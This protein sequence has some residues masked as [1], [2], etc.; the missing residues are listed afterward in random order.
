[1]DYVFKLPRDPADGRFAVLPIVD[2]VIIAPGPGNDEQPC[3]GTFNWG[4]NGNVY[5]RWAALDL[6][7]ICVEG[8][9][10][11]WPRFETQ[12]C[13]WQ[14]SPG[15]LPFGAWAVSEQESL[16]NGVIPIEVANGGFRLKAGTHH[17]ELGDPAG[18]TCS[19]RCAIDLTIAW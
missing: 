8:K 15:F 3:A 14:C 6:G 5:D 1:M 17:F 13:G 2:N 9:W 12:A 18:G 16:A 7:I 11:V 10:C 4:P 19:I